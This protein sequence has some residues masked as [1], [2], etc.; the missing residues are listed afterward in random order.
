MQPILPQ[1]VTVDNTGNV[2]GIDYTRITAVLVEAVKELTAQVA[3]LS[4]KG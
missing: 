1:V 3:Q 2:V 4:A